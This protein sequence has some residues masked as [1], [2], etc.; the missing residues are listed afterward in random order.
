ML[1]QLDA[2]ALTIVVKIVCLA[3]SLTFELKL[4]VSCR[5]TH[6]PATNYLVAIASFLRIKE[7]G[8]QD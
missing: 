4:L 8:K 6:I 1:L 3:T 2:H 7:F 5:E